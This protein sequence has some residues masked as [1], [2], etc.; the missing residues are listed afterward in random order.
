MKFFPPPPKSMTAMKHAYKKAKGIE[1][2]G[3]GG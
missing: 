3:G 1:I 2:G